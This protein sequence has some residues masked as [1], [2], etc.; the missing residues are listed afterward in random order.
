MK[1]DITVDVGLEEDEVDNISFSS[2]ID[3]VCEGMVIPKEL[4]FSKSRPAFVCEAR[5]VAYYLGWLMTHRSLPSLGRHMGRDHTT[6]MYGRDKC[7]TLMR[8]SEEFKDK[9]EMIKKLAYRNERKRKQTAAI[10][11][12]DIKKEVEAAARKASVRFSTK[13]SISGDKVVFP[14]INPQ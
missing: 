6:V 11:L 8:R 13:G 10:K 14:R 7:I 9:V 1:V 5:F 4:L 2:I 12:A 3:A